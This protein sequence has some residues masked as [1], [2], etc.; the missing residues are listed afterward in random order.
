MLSF[1]PVASA[2]E[3]INLTIPADQFFS[4]EF[5]NLCQPEPLVVE[6]N[7]HIVGH[8][9]GDPT[10]ADFREGVHFNTQGVSAVGQ[11]SGLRYSVSEVSHSTENVK[12][13]SEFT[14][15]LTL[16]VV[17]QGSGENSQLTDVIHFTTNANGEFTATVIG[18]HF[19]CNGQPAS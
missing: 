14:G 15:V 8:V 6:G 16:N 10:T 19:H 5:A 12:S 7:I 1:A 3:H 2:G 9:Q 4:P 13:A 17:S 18:G 11:V